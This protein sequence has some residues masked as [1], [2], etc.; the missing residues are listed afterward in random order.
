MPRMSRV[1]TSLVVALLACASPSKQAVATPA[2]TVAQAGG[3]AKASGTDGETKVICE[4]ERPTG[5]N[6]P[7]RVCRNATDVEMQRLRTQDALRA[8]PNTQRKGD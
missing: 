4:M 2:A 8:L 6:I 5:S 3:A 1:L 7:E